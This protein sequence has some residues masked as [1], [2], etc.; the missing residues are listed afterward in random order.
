M[1][2]NCL[3][4]IEQEIADLYPSCSVTRAMAKK[5]N[6]Y[7]GMHDINL[8]DTLIGQSF[9]D[10]I[11]NSLSPSQ[12]DIQNNFDT[13]RLNTDHSPS[14]SKDQDYDQLSRPQLCKEQRSESEISP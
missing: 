4:P 2:I 5:P 7:N 12:S 8:A 10:E 3:I 1:L 6:Q 9:N 13:S 14:I 11:S